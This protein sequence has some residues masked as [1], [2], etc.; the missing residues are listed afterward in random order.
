MCMLSRGVLRLGAVCRTAVTA[1]QLTAV[2]VCNRPVTRA[3]PAV[4]VTAASMATD[5]A[6]AADVVASEEGFDVRRSK[7]AF[8]LTPKPAGADAADVVLLEF[9]EV[10]VGDDTVW[11]MYHTFTP[12]ALRG[13]GLAGQCVKAALTD[14]ASRGYKVIPSCSVSAAPCAACRSG[15]GVAHVVDCAVFVCC[16]PS[17]RR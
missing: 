3:V 2:R 9:E 10:K 12:E 5:A 1:A 4:T 16:G 8:T 17:L 14:A 11:Q 7:G 15:T 6:A 13:R